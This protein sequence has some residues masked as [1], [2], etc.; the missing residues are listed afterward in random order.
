MSLSSRYPLARKFSFK[1]HFSPLDVTVFFS[2]TNLFRVPF[3]PI[4]KGCH[5]SGPHL[6]VIKMYLLLVSLSKSC[7]P[8][9]RGLNSIRSGPRMG[10]SDIRITCH[11]EHR[12]GGREIGGLKQQT[13]RL[14]N[15]QVDVY[16]GSEFCSSNNY[17]KLG[18]REH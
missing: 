7:P 16:L 11:V 4:S 12:W 2:Q 3:F 10:Y 1:S 8:P 13:P 6:N 18:W 9:S 17:L 5:K 15:A 14:W